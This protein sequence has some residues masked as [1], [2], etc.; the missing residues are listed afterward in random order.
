[1]K[2]AGYANGVSALHGTVSRRMW[3]GLWP[4]RAES[5]VPIRHI[6]NGVHA[7]SWLAPP[8][9]TLYERYLGR[10][11]QARMCSADVWEGIETIDDDEFWEMHQVMK[12]R[13]LNYV[14]R[15]LAQQ[16]A[17]GIV[18]LA[19]PAPRFD[20]DVLTLCVARRFAEYKRA[21]LLLSDVERLARIANTPGRGL[22]IIFAGKA[23]PRDDEGKRVLQ[24]VVG[25]TRDARFRNRIAFVADYDFGV[26]RHLVQGTDVWLNTPRRPLEACGTSGQ[27]ALLNGGLNLSVLD[28]WWAEGFDGRNGFAVGDGHVHSD[29]AVQDARDAAALYDVLEGEV[30]P[31]YYSRGTDNVPHGWVARIKHSIASLAPHFNADRMLRDY[32]RQCYLPA[33]GARTSSTPCL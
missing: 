5:E 29:P 4:E 6:T 18:E 30:I 12:R 1:L 23:H 13:L 21:M 2:S 11:W 31:L 3:Q 32:V 9:F 26:A 22:Q 19:A 14:S 8:M 7:S 15:R 24:Q 33:A 28:G 16:A 25:L 20:G 10:D 17:G 27:K